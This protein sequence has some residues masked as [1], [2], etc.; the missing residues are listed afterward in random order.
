MPEALAMGIP[1]EVF[2]HLNPKKLK[3]FFTAKK[4]K[5]VELDQF[6]HVW[7]GTYGMSALTTAISKCFAKNSTAEYMKENIM[8]RVANENLTELEKQREVDKFYA[9]QRARR[10]NWKRNRKRSDNI[11]ETD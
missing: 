7:I 8:S 4:K 6:V 2:W 10:A 1:W 3:P 11:A 5:L 9:E